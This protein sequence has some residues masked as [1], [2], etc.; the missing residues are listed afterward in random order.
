MKQL[1]LQSQLAVVKERDGHGQLIP[2]LRLAGRHS[3]TPN[4]NLRI[5]RI[6]EKDL[7]EL[8]SAAQDCGVT[9]EEY[10]SELVEVRMVELRQIREEAAEHAKYAA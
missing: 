3:E 8:L 5:V 6:T 1:E 4:E 9:V 2:Q 10:I 7:P